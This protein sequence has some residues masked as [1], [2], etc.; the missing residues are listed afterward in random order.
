MFRVYGLVYRVHGSKFKVIEFRDFR[1][2]VIRFRLMVKGNV[3]G[4]RVI[5]TG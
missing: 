2:R 3:Y 5:D 4:F 1:F